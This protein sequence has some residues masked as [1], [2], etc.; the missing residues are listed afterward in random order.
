MHVSSGCSIW[1]R[2]HVRDTGPEAKS[3]VALPTP[4]MLVILSLAMVLWEL[5]TLRPPRI[6][7]K[8]FKVSLHLPRFHQ[9]M[10]ATGKGG[11]IKRPGP[12]SSHSL[13]SG[14]QALTF[15]GAN[16]KDGAK[17]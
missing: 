14:I 10:E 15:S 2:V 3:R 11:L 4:T 5:L 12:L 7:V 9:S 16:L 6:Q 1:K 13:D 17:C 8:A